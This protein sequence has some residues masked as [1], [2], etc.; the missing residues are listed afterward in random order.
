MGKLNFSNQLA[1]VAMILDKLQV[2]LCEDT[3]YEIPSAKET[4]ERILKAMDGLELLEKSH[5]EAFKRI[6]EEQDEREEYLR[7]LYGDYS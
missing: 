2:E 3:P 1:K 7:H 5:N 6:H 4:R